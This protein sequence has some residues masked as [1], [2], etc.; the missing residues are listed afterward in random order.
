MIEYFKQH[1]EEICSVQ[2]A[3]FEAHRETL[4]KIADEMTKCLASGHKI[5]LFGN[6]GSAADAQHIAAEF[7]VRLKENRRAYPS[8]A[9]STDTSVITACGND[10]GY[11]LIFARQVEAF[12]QDGDVIIALSTSGNSPNV[13]A[14]VDEA[15]KKKISVIAITGDGGG[16]L[17]GKADILLD[18]KSKK[19]MRIQETY[20][21]FLHTLCDITE[22]RLA[23]NKI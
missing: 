8:M 21:T 7:V 18:I 10:L 22:Q 15:H 23:G 5:I 17:K 13:L 6:G 12:G 4:P 19:A 2:K 11:D 14:A 3:S 20:M 9:F 16:K 1:V